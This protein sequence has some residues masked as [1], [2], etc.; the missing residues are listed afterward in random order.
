MKGQTMT[1]IVDEQGRWFIYECKKNK[2]PQSLHVAHIW[3]LFMDEY[4]NNVDSLSSSIFLLKIGFGSSRIVYNDAVFK[5]E[6][7]IYCNL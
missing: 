6:V 1:L 2:W 4:E 7:K 3:K 5:Y